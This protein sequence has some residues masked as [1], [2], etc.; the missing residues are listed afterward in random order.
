MKAAAVKLNA[1]PASHCGA[2]VFNVR[3]LTMC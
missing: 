1:R 2:Q 3:A